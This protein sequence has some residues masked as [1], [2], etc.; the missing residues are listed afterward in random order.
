MN[1]M[2][3]S[4]APKG[5]K[6]LAIACW[7]LLGL[8]CGGAIIP[9]LGFAV[10]LIAAPVLIAAFVMSILLMN[11]GRAAQGV[12]ILIL[13]LIVAPTFILF[14]PM[15][16]TLTAAAV[17]E[18]I[19]QEMDNTQ[20]GSRTSGGSS[21]QGQF[22]GS[23]R[24]GEIANFRDSQWTVATASDK[25]RS[26]G[27]TIASKN[28]SGRFIYVR[29]VVV[30]KTNSTDSLFVPPVLKDSRGRE[31]T[32]IDGM[33]FVLPEDE[34]GISMEA[35]PAGVPKSFSAI[36]EVPSDATGLKFMSRSLS[37]QSVTKPIELDL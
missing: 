1:T 32:E 2:D 21:A 37:S 4:N 27:G 11:K 16:S 17:A 36:Y 24:I 7:I 14:A 5:G 34:T 15:F 10:W 9:G 19:S 22:S 30:N 20:R 28:T 8:S 23:L 13:S 25:G 3:K 29:Y 12:I 35:L 26:I 31:F 18:G 33:E 6:G